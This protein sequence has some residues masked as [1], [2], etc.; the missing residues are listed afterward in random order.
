MVSSDLNDVICS[1]LSK[2]VQKHW[3]VPLENKTMSATFIDCNHY[4][5][6]HCLKKS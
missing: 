1:K 6:Y 4:Y 5:G 3:Y 2:N